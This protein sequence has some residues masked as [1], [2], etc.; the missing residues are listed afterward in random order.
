MIARGIVAAA[1][2]AAAYG[3]AGLPSSPAMADGIEDFYRGR[4]MTILVGY[5]GRSTDS[6]YAR[7]FS[8]HA[9]RAGP[10]P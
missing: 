9:D 8:A 5:G 7:A 3:A 2:A 10:L 6:I 4:T 1:I